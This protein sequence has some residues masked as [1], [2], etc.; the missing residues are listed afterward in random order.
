MSMLVRMSTASGQRFSI[1]VTPGLSRSR[2]LTTVIG[3][4]ALTVCRR[5]RHLLKANKDD[6]IVI[7]AFRL[8]NYIDDMLI[9]YVIRDRAEERGEWCLDE[10]NSGGPHSW[11]VAILARSDLRLYQGF[12]R[13][14][15]VELTSV[16]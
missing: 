11:H 10:T 7:T 14:L 8:V 1:G 5:W 2:R 12:V 9:L 13:F 16:V 15:I 4:F 6:Q 3:V